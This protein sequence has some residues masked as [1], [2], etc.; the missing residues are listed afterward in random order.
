[1]LLYYFEKR[2]IINF[3]KGNKMEYQITK[4]YEV[5]KAVVEKIGK[6]Y[7]NIK[8]LLWNMCTLV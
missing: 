4:N 2:V 3:T 6:N 1:M 7:K 5:A 8:A